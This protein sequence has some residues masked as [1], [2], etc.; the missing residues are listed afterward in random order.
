MCTPVSL[1]ELVLHAIASHTLAAAGLW[2]GDGAGLGGGGLLPAPRFVFC[3]KE[4]NG[5]A[6]A[7]F[8]AGRRMRFE[9]ALQL[10]VLPSPR[11]V[12]EYRYYLV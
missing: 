1:L 4:A 9:G 6:N 10:R 7:G 3:I 5:V 2:R 8:G 12:P 11:R